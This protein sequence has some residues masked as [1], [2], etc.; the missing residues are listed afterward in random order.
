MSLYYVRRGRYRVKELNFG[1]KMERKLENLG[2]G[3][4]CV[5]EKLHNPKMVSQHDFL[6]SVGK[7]SLERRVSNSIFVEKVDK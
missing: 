2:F 6:T 5:V 3:V 1:R 7:I 4:D